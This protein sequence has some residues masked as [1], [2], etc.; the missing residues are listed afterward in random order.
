MKPREEAEGA[1]AGLGTAP[2]LP[3]RGLRTTTPS[4]Q[5]AGLTHSA[6][7][8]ECGGAARGTMGV[9]VCGALAALRGAAWWPRARPAGRERS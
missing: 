6:L 1:T 3:G 8:R 9:V 4:M 7:R 2:L 5:R